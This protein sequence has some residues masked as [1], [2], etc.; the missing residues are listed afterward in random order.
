MV[1]GELTGNGDLEIERPAKIE[2]A[3]PG[4]ITFLSNMRYKKFVTTTHAGA[5][6][7]SPNVADAELSLRTS[8]ISVIHVADPYG[9]FQEVAEKFSTPRAPLAR[10]IDAGA[11]IAGTATLGEDV[12]VGPH[13]AIGQR[14]VIGARTS[15]YAG[16]I[17]GDNVTIG[18][19]TVL[20][21][22]VV[23]QDGC[24]VGDRV[25]I[26]SSTTVGSDGFGFTPRED[27]TYEKIP[28]RGIVVIEDDV[29]IGANCTIDRA[30][31][32]ETRIK[33]GVKL[34]NLIHVAHNVVV[35][36][37]TVIAAQTGISGSTKLGKGCRIAG[38]VGFVG[39]LTIADRT[40]IMAQ[41]G[42][43]KSIEEDGQTYFGYPA[44]PNAEALRII[45]AWRSLPSLLIQV[46]RLEERIKELEQEIRQNH[47]AENT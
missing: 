27:G 8:P 29:E 45:A 6:F 36:E 46:R 15:L 4:E 28:Q 16:V 39:H 24:K 43:A 30:T 12:A 23:I 17:V 11:S 35:G 34:D 31:L 2:E 33:R 18:N 47:T 20:Y 5:I 7:L 25:V 41:S 42:V 10:G 37:D 21:P 22:H 44:F 3:G 40:T 13:V 14:S 19:D 32:G 9:A 38:Q 1:H 26:N